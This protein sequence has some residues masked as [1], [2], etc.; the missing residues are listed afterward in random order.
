MEF[1]LLFFDFSLACHLRVEY[2]A[3]LSVHRAI[4]VF[5]RSLCASLPARQIETILLIGV[6]VL[7]AGAYPAVEFSFTSI[8]CVV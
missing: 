1:L 7:V 8:Q 5:F 4:F 6:T 2:V 3:G